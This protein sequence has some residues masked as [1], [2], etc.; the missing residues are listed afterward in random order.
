MSR[1]HGLTCGLQLGHWSAL[2]LC[3][4]PQVPKHVTEVDLRPL[5]EPYGEIMCLNV[6]RTQRGQGPSAGCAF[7]EV[8][9]C[10]SVHAL[11]HTVLCAAL[12]HFR[13][14]CHMPLHHVR[15]S[16]AAIC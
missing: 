11:L 8:C 10:G 1:L 2:T 15:I 6:L 13:S 14:R 7:V 16:N 9:G 5:F 4:L 12:I 3:A